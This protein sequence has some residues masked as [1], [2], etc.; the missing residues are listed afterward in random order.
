MKRGGLTCETQIEPDQ[1]FNG[2]LVWSKNLG[3]A[4]NF[5]FF[6]NPAR[7]SFTDMKKTLSFRLPLVKSYARGWTRGFTFIELM[8]VVLL[9][10]GLALFAIPKFKEAQ[11]RQYAA[12]SGMNLK[13]INSAITQWDVEHGGPPNATASGI[14]RE[15]IS[16][17]EL[18]PTGNNSPF[19]DA[20]LSYIEDT[21]GIWTSPNF[22]NDPCYY[23]FVF[24]DRTG[25]LKGAVVSSLN[26][27]KN[28]EP[29]VTA[30]AMN[31]D[32]FTIN[33]P[34]GVT[35]T[36]PWVNGME[37]VGRWE[38]GGF[39]SVAKGLTPPSGETDKY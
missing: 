11:K 6:E 30:E 24:L 31:A 7:L 3:S 9:I 4:K 16:P 17:V 34:G 15:E 32:D 22:P 12:R 8:V 10:A 36:R 27:V 14:A 38:S 2:D 35:V 20:M 37:D 13:A 5:S 33:L 18:D 19:A 23:Y 39:D 29:G 28:Y 21:A 26:G 1:K 25:T